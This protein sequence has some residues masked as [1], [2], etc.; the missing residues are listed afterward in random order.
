M[1]KHFNYRGRAR[2]LVVAVTL[3]AIALQALK[4]GSRGFLLHQWPT[5]GMW[6]QLAMVIGLLVY[7]WEGKTWARVVTAVY[8]SLAAIAGAATLII[9][10]SSAE[11]ALRAAS[12]LIILLAGAA[13]I[14]LWLIP[15]VGN[16]D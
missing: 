13:A 10:W 15:V 8:Y 9:V 16:L 11:A 5:I 14:L 6:G 1:A 4:L 7:L 2:A 12:I 3:I